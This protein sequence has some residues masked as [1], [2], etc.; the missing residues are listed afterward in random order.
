MGDFES[1]A[2]NYDCEEH[3]FFAAWHIVKALASKNL[4]DD[5]RKLL[6]DLDTHLSTVTKAA[7]S[8]ARQTREVEDQLK[9]AQKKVIRWESTGSKIWDSGPEEVSG[10]MQAVYEI[11]RLTESLRSLLPNRTG[12]QRELLDQA[13][14]ILQI[15]MVRLEEELIHILA[16]NKPSLDPQ[17]ISFRS[18]EEDAVYEESLV[19]VEDDSNSI[20]EASERGIEPKDHVVNLVH[21]DVVS[22]IKCIAN[23]MFASHYEQEFCRA[24]VNFWKD[25]LSECFSILGIDRLTSIED[26]MTMEW[27]YL[28]CKIKKWVYAVKIIVRVYLV[29]EKRLFDQV[30]GEF[31]YVCCTCF[32]EASKESMLSLMNFGEAITIGPRSPEKLFRLLD[33]YEVL[34]GLLPDVDSLFSEEV[35]SFVRTEFH[36]LLVRLGDAARATFI[37]FGDAVA[38]SISASPFPG[39]AVHPLTRYVMNYLNVAM[40]YAGSLNSILDVQS[41]EDMVFC[42]LAR[43]LR[44]IISKLESNL[45]I[46]S[47]LYKDCSLRHVFMMN[48][49]QY[50]V[51]KVQNSDL[52]T[53]FGDEWIRDYTGKFQQ[54]AR[55]YGRVTWSPILAMI[56]DTGNQERLNPKEQY[57]SFNVAFEGVYKSQTGWLVPDPELKKDLRI[58][59][60]Q[61]VIHAYQTFA[62][63]YSSEKYI[64]YTAEE[65][66]NYILD[67]FNGSRRSLPNTRKR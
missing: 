33:M 36:E 1:I 12:K 24:F 63:K 37:E 53:F 57:R 41:G 65:L 26:L 15:A 58:S 8:K 46:K 50:M 3:M 44:L 16:Q 29:G 2:P 47:G 11:Q 4:S 54:H 48:N 19:S 61:N 51:R 34:S 14:T 59:I 38:S 25:A 45:E 40:D 55:N 64:K 56:R 27:K 32:I 35:G 39:G 9:L 66:E 67:L 5:A 31:G 20:E 21:P 10:Y 49:I 6:S 60:S 7:Q 28:N 43:Y 22:D 13:D 17:C 62:G 23:V 30:L 18:C 52:N 42:P